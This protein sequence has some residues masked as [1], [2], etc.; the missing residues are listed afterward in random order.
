[1]PNEQS[2][3]THL[4]ISSADKPLI[5]DRA[6]AIKI[7]LSPCD[8]R[9]LRPYLGLQLRDFGELAGPLRGELRSLRHS[10]CPCSLGLCR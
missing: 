10:G 9:L 8:Q 6:G 5:E 2:L 4:Q 7:L 3:L 1:M